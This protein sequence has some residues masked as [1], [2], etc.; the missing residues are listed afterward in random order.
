MRNPQMGV[1]PRIKFITEV[2]IPNMVANDS[3]SGLSQVQKKELDCKIQCVRE[4][5]RKA[6]K[7]GKRK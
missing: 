2:V 6:L 1:S 3:T 5:Y 7:E 4:K